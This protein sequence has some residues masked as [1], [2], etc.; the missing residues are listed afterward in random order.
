MIRLNTYVLS[1]FRYPRIVVPLLCCFPT[2]AK[3]ISVTQVGRFGRAS[4][5]RDKQCTSSARYSLLLERPHRRQPQPLESTYFTPLCL[6]FA[7][8]PSCIV[9]CLCPVIA[10]VEHT[11]DLLHNITNPSWTRY[12]N[13]D[14]HLLQIVI[15][16]FDFAVANIEI[17]R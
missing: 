9:L 2:T 7:S 8:R 16:R 5:S 4:V 14:K 11:A 10:F 3:G 15:P 6:K 12:S 13:R 17:A 1:T